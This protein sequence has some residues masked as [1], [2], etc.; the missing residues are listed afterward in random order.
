MHGDGLFEATCLL[1][2][3]VERQGLLLRVVP[4]HQRLQLEPATT[5]HIWNE[6]SR[7]SHSCMCAHIQGPGA[8]YIHVHTEKPSREV[9]KDAPVEEP[10]DEGAE[11]RGVDGLGR[12]QLIL[13]I[14]MEWRIGLSGGCCGCGCCD[15]GCRRRRRC[16]VYGWTH[17]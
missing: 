7:V 6:K 4:V 9:K 3:G 14:W 16:G 12:L 1:A 15:Y 13:S 11:A 17:A 10:G 8:W 2:H 5:R